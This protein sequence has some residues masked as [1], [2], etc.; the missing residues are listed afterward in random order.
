MPGK[1]DLYADLGRLEELISHYKSLSRQSDEEAE[2]NKFMVRLLQKRYKS[3]SE[4]LDWRDKC[5]L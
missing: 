2:F 4:F 3:I 1:I 5:L